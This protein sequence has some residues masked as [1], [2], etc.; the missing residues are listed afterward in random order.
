MILQ[1]SGVAPQKPQREQHWRSSG[2]TLFLVHP[3]YV[4]HSRGIS[5]QG[6]SHNGHTPP[7]HHSSTS[8]HRSGWCQWFRK[9]LDRSCTALLLS[10]SRR[11]EEMDQCCCTDS[12]LGERFSHHFCMGCL[13]RNCSHREGELVWGA[14]QY[15]MRG[16]LC[17]VTCIWAPPHGDGF[18]KNSQTV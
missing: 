6:D 9:P 11:L 18:W 2:T 14:D 8:T 15:A 10:D 13:D 3:R 16:I 4:P 1:K 12:S 7:W 5:F 17:P